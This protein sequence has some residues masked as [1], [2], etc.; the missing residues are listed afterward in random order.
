MARF[1]K[2]QS[3]NPGGRPKAAGEIRELARKH[4]QA[5]IRALVDALQDERTKVSAAVALLDRGYGKPAQ[6]HAGPD[7]EGPMKAIIEV[8]TGVSRAPTD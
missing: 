1:Q 8:A 6:A 3:G 5:A 2:G 4:T 7:G